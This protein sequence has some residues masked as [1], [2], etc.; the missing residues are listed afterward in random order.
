[1]SRFEYSATI[2]TVPATTSK[3][4]KRGRK[5]RTYFDF[6]SGRPLHATHQQAIRLKFKTPI[7]IGKKVQ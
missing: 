1:M 3:E 6:D 4:N 2:D 5:T 7:I